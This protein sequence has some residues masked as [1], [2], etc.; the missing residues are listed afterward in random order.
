ME[1]NQKTH[2]NGISLSDDCWF[3]TK[4][5]VTMLYL[6][7]CQIE[8][9]I[10]DSNQSIQ[11]LT[12]TFT[13]LAEKSLSESNANQE[14]VWTSSEMRERINQAIT[15]FQFYDRINQRLQHVS[16]GLEKMSDMFNDTE[17]LNDQTAWQKIQSEVEASYSMDAERKVFQKIM[18]GASVKEAMAYYQSQV[19]QQ[20]NNDDI[21]LF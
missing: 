6:A 9:S 11:Q 21:E 14:T 12:D 17:R 1:A 3:H 2:T 19:Q 15:A 16:N 18:D 7:I 4:S 20:H 13:R 10:A 5:T 8:T